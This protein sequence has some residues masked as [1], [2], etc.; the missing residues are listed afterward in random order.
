MEDLS[1]DMAL[2]LLPHM[3]Y[4]ELKQYA[5]TS[6]RNLSLVRYFFGKYCA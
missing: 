6:R 2:S 5:L 3:G 4:V 1:D